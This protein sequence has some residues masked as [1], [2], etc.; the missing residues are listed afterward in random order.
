[1]DPSGGAGLT[2]SDLT[3]FG[4]LAG[5]TLDVKYRPAFR[6]APAR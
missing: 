1:M 4:T 5:A 2:S 6:S 3:R